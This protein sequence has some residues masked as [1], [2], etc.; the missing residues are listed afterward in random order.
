I[1]RSAA[2]NSVN[3]RPVKFG[4]SNIEIIQ[5][6]FDAL[7]LENANGGDLYLYPAFMAIVDDRKNLGLIEIEEL[8]FYFH[9]QRF[10]EEEKVPGD[11][12]IIEYTWAK[13]NKNG[14]PDKRFKANYQIPVCKYGSIKLSSSTGL[15][16]AYLMSSFEKAEEFANAMEAYQQAVKQNR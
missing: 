8:E 6:S 7:H 2:A 9:S 4:F 12:S 16:E 15:N 3:R 11:A 13:V 5:S 10:I 14:T 1:T